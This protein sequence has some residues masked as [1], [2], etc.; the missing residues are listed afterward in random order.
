MPLHV[1]LG[2]NELALSSDSL[3]EKQRRHAATA[4]RSAEGC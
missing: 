4:Q 1:F 2:M 3:D